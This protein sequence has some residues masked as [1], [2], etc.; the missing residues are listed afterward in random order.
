LERSDFMRG[1]AGSRTLVGTKPCIPTD[2]RTRK[3]ARSL[4]A[5]AVRC[6]VRAMPCPA[7]DGPH[8][9]V[10]VQ[11][12][13]RRESRQQHGGVPGGGGGAQRRDQLLQAHS[14]RPTQCGEQQG[15]HAGK[16]PP[17]SH[18][19]ATAVCFRR[20]CQLLAEG[21]RWPQLLRDGA[22]PSLAPAWMAQAPDTRHSLSLS[23]WCAAR[24]S[25]TPSSRHP[26]PSPTPSRPPP[27]C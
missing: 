24:G 6:A 4:S 10:A 3:D 2:T 22:C 16:W 17:S 27:L 23:P 21:V 5:S 15:G 19:N 18:N 25:L 7:P 9:L 8:G 20:P 12:G 14:V 26:G 13:L 1:G 11:G